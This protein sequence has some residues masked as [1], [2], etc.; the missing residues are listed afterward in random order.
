LDIDAEIDRSPAV[1]P[2]ARHP[3]PAGACEH[4]R[5]RST[6][7]SADQDQVIVQAN[8]AAARVFRCSIDDLVG[9]AAIRSAF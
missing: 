3:P 6:P 8:P 1:Q 4:L 9:A 5:G 7:S 2:H